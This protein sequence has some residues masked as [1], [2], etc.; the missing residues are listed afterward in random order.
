MTILRKL[1]ATR[2]SSSHHPSSSTL[3]QLFSGGSKSLAGVQVNDR[4]A[5]LSSAV[6]SATRLYAA[7]S[8]MLSRTVFERLPGGGKQEAP[9][10]HYAQKIA[11]RPNQVDNPFL[12]EAVETIHQLNAGNGIG[13][14]VRD[15]SGVPLEIFRV[16][17]SRVQPPRTLNDGRVV[18]DVTDCN[19]QRQI[20]AENVFHVSNI[21][22]DDGIWGKGIIT[23]ARETIGTA[24]AHTRKGAADL[25]N[26]SVPPLVIEHPGKM[27]DV[28]RT[29]FRDE[30]EL[31]H[32]G[33]DNSG[34]MAILQEGMK[35]NP[36]GLPNKDMEFIALGNYTVEDIA[37]W[38]SVPPHKIGSLLRATFSNI[39]QQ[40]LEYVIYS[41]IP[42]LRMKEVE[43]DRKI[44]LPQDQD[45]F[46]LKYNVDSLLRG[47]PEKRASALQT[48]FINGALQLDEWRDLEDR[49]PLAD[50]LGKKHFVPRNLIPVEQAIQGPQ[51]VAPKP[52]KPAAP[53]A[54]AETKSTTDLVSFRKGFELMYSQTYHRLGR[55]EAMAARKAAEKPNKFLAWLD[56]FYPEHA[57]LMI[58]AVQP[59]MEMQLRVVDRV[60]EA[61]VPIQANRKVQQLAETR[62]NRSRER[63]LT[64]SECKPSELAH[65]VEGFARECEAALPGKYA[66]EDAGVDH[67]L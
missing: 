4:T 51:P 40:S 57:K 28:A 10:D 62:C 64:L 55:K 48:Q 18:F 15:G 59:T 66:S 54:P 47:D 27:T 22:S 6:W 8:G 61:Q 38:Y 53:P 56:E 33:A 36:L 43:F 44:L 13:E 37:R 2:D 50:G 31:F 49:N 41:L 11:K 52:S 29:N 58:E 21:V 46:F 24:I 65:A 20:L 5:L 39:D 7:S 14:I 23:H 17:P 35:A 1:F 67:A 63:L 42:I 34:K 26:R 32:K 25:G 30:W 45:R 60:D 9:R 16:H 12:F 3:G 19:G